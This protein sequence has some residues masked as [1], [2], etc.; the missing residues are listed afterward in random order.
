MCIQF[1][2]Q[3][4]LQ[5]VEL[6]EFERRLKKLVYDDD[7]ISVW[8]LVE[9]FKTCRGFEDIDNTSSFTLSLMTSSFLRK[10][11]QGSP[12]SAQTE[13]EENGRSMQEINEQKMNQL[14]DAKIYIPYLMLLGIL[15][16]KATPRQRAT[17]F[18]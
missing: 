1:E 10:D 11:C 6:N 5:R 3:F 18:F 9:T 15:Y 12:S 14:P 8:T 4:P 17:K 13:A 7:Y 2:K 16:C